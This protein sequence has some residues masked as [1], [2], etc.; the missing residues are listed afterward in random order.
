M[1]LVSFSTSPSRNDIFGLSFPVSI[2]A[3]GSQAAYSR[4]TYL[5]IDHYSR[6]ARASWIA[7]RWIGLRI[8][9]IGAAFRAALA[10]YLIYGRS[11]SAANAGFSLNMSVAFCTYIF[12]LIRLYNE[13]EVQANRC[14]HIPLLNMSQNNTMTSLERIQGYIDIEHEPK[15]TST[16]SPPAGW[17]SS[18]EIQV[19]NLS[20]RYSKVTASVIFKG[21]FDS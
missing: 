2:R 3:Y 12:F 5:L 9:A 20:A 14:V 13:L 6:T 16:G 7:N 1:V 8:D 18:G 17:P 19:E 21:V 11:L 10:H 15:S 4:A